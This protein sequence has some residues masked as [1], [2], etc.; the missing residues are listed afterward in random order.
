MPFPP[1][2]R[3]HIVIG[4]P[5]QPNPIVHDAKLVSQGDGAMQSW[6]TARLKAPHCQFLQKKIIFCQCK[7]ELQ[8]VFV[9]EG[10]TYDYGQN[11]QFAPKCVHIDELYCLSFLAVVELLLR[12][13]QWNGPV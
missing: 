10:G 9:Q 11:D 1:C 12:K 3:A 7:L 6:A 8:N 4:D 13:M 2:N 5:K